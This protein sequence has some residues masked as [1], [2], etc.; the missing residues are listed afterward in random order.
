MFYLIYLS[1]YSPRLNYIS[2]PLVYFCC[3]WWNLFRYK[4]TF[5]S[6]LYISEYQLI[7]PTVLYQWIAFHLDSLSSPRSSL[8]SFC[9]L[10]PSLF[11]SCLFSSNLSVR[12]PSR[13]LQSFFISVF[14][15]FI[16]NVLSSNSFNL[17]LIYYASI[18]HSI[19]LFL[20]SI[21]PFIYLFINLLFIQSSLP[22]ICHYLFVCPSINEL[23]N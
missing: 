22:L 2:V 1:I 17:S 10:F 3:F 23:V 14:V 15:S 9:P 19:N 13:C 21:H 11:F 4:C 6:I 12:F 20:I 16:Q 8:L 7:L 5:L 18:L